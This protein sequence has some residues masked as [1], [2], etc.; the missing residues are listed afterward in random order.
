[1]DIEYREHIGQKR[2]I[3]KDFR[4]IFVIVLTLSPAHYH[5][6]VQKISFIVFL[7]FSYC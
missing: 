3:K 6:D 2:H 7:T 4:K 1:M 5:W